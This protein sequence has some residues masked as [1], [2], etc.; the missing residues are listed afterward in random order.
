MS[1]QSRLR[2][3]KK[4]LFTG[5]GRG[6]ARAGATA[7]PASGALWGNNEKTTEDANGDG[8]SVD[9]PA[10]A[11]VRAREGRKG[12][13]GER[14]ARVEHVVERRG[15]YVAHGALVRNQ[16]N[17]QNHWDKSKTDITLLI[18]GYSERSIMTI[19]CRADLR[20]VYV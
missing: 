9:T 13:G 3:R 19:L 12:G 7:S 16:N 11:G 2:E 8:R 18:H 4:K 1:K 6:R 14:V 5:L 10:H 20:F 17:V 15:P